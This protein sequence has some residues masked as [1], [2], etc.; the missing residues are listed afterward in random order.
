MR[1]LAVRGAGMTIISGAVGVGIQIVA[2]V[3]LG[4]LLA[5]SDFGFVAMVTTFSLLL[6]NGPA[7]GFNDSVLQRKE[8]T[9]ELAS[10]MFWINFG[11]GLILTAGFAA[12]GP[13]LAHFYHAAPVV[14][15]TAVVSISVLISSVS[16]MHVALL[17]RAMRFAAVAKNDIVARAMGVLTSIC[18]GFAGWGYWALVMGVCALALSTSIGAFIL[19][20]WL[21]GR[22][23]RAPGV[24]SALNFASHVSGRYCINYFARNSDN[25]LVGW[26]FGAF[27]LGFYKKAYD[28]FALSAGQLVAATSSVAVSALSRVRD[29]RDQYLRYLMG[30]VAIMSMIGM[31]LA[32]DLT[33]VGPDLIRV[34]LGPKWGQTGRIFTYFAPGIGMMVVYYINGWIHVSI[35]RPDRWLIW[36][37]VEWTVTL[38]LFLVGLHWGPEGIA[39]AWCVSFWV[40]TVPAMHYAGKPINLGAG[41]VMAVVWRYIVAALLAGLG[42]NAVMHHV[43]W[44]LEMKGAG[45]AALRVAVV[46]AIFLAFYLAAI[47]ALHGGAAPLRTARKLLRELKARPKPA[48]SVASQTASGETIA[49]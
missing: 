42:A 25:L 33:L 10:A 28:L 11:I 35:G 34:L 49:L 3:V 30:S 8:I 40:L 14:G 29:D 17:K 41:A 15:I 27:S 5:P 31:G 23:R 43:A 12:S 44:L 6:I 2:A 9:H 32:G 45:G 21:P 1:R 36:G 22:P 16:V 39:L 47:V 18:F 7:N 37:A 38:S 48:D 13:L 20:P 24:C 19:C 4:R 46:S 26:R